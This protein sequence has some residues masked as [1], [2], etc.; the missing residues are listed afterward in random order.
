MQLVE[1]GGKGVGGVVGVPGVQDDV[2][3]SA[4]AAAVLF[5]A[6][7]RVLIAWSHWSSVS[8]WWWTKA[9]VRSPTAVRISSRVSGVSIVQ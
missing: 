4:D 7:S 9:A 2:D 3:E 1:G 5:A 6:V 8:G